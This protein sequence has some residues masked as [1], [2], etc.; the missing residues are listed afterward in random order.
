MAEPTPSPDFRYTVADGK[1]DTIRGTAVP[2]GPWRRPGWNR[3]LPTGRVVTERAV[4]M[5]E[6]L[7]HF[8]ERIQ[9]KEPTVTRNEP[10]DGAQ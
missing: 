8:A 7:F 4:A 6:G 1:L 5:T 3:C 2:A 9:K 10:M